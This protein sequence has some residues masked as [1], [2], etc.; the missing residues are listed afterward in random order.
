MSEFRILSLDGG[1]IRGA[2]GASFLA[3]LEEQIDCPLYKYFDLIVGTSTGGIIA[4]GIAAGIPAMDIKSF[5]QE[6]G[7]KIFAKKKGNMIRSWFEPKY[8]HRVLESSLLSAFGDRRMKDAKTKLIVPA[9]NLT[10]GKPTTFKTPHLHEASTRDP[11]LRMAD[12]ALATCAAPTYFSSALMG[13]HRSAHVDGGLWA[14]NPALVGYVEA[15]RLGVTAKP[16]IL[17]IGTGERV[18]N[19]KPPMNAGKLWWATK[20]VPITLDAQSESSEYMAR[21]LFGDDHYI[22]VNFNLP[23]DSWTL[24][25][26]E[27]LNALLHFGEQEAH[28]RIAALRSMIFAKPRPDDQIEECRTA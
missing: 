1:G 10:T 18:F 3:K 2:F 16:T 25:N 13:E 5:Y 15:Q 17:S 22:R 6:D 9:L 4:L 21:F 26:V 28:N 27:H 14:N 20:A 24:D 12:V 8:T 19:L 23:N 7:P 11:E